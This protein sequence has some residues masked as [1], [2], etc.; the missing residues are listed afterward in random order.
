[1]KKLSL[2]IFT[3]VLTGCSFGQQLLNVSIDSFNNED[4]VIMEFSAEAAPKMF[5]LKDPERVVIDF[6]GAVWNGAKREILSDSPRLSKIRWAQNSFS[7]GIARV[8]VDVK[9]GIETELVKEKEGRKIILVVRDSGAMPVVAANQQEAATIEP[10]AKK[11]DIPVIEQIENVPETQIAPIG[12][13][14]EPPRKI[15]LP[16]LSRF[17]KFSVIV[18]GEKID[19]GRMQVFDGK[20]LLVPLK[21]LI[22]PL[23]FN[24]ELEDSGKMLKARS[25][26]GTEA[27]FY[28]NSNRMDV[29]GSERLMSRQAKKIKGKLYVPFIS[30]V[31][32]LGYS[33]MW[34]P[35]A[36]KLFVL[37]RITGISYKDYE[38]SKSVVLKSSAVFAT[39]EAEKKEKPLVL[40]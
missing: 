32:W 31:K 28:L 39:Y 34:Q 29:N 18:N 35:D 7:P 30:A 3:L 15:I 1:M 2:F 6:E 37:P 14:I 22:S 36:K 10:G 26:A 5:T 12:T 9:E 16:D 4:R 23:G 17:R 11:I 38:G 33:A 20:V 19:T 25:A 8:V 40:I 13:A 27:V 24:I 21:D